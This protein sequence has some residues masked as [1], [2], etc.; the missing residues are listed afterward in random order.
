MQRDVAH[1]QIDLAE[2]GPDQTLR[3][4]IKG[5][6]LHQGRAVG[7]RQLGRLLALLLGIEINTQKTSPSVS[8]PAATTSTLNFGT[9]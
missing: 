2:T 5:M 4:W 3:E 9:G 8:K 6:S 7:Q 1:R